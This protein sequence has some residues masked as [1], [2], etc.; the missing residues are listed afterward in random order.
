MNEKKKKK[1]TGRIIAALLFFGIG[2]ALINMAVELKGEAQGPLL[3]VSAADLSAHKIHSGDYIHIPANAMKVTS[4]VPLTVNYSDKPD[5]YAFI[6]ENIPNY[7]FYTDSK[8]DDLYDYFSENKNAGEPVNIELKGRGNT[9]SDISEEPTG[10][11]DFAQKNGFVESDFF[12]A[13]HIGIT[14]SG[15]LWPYRLCLFAAFIPVLIG[16]LL[17]ISLF[18]RKTA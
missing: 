5:G 3:E 6:L 2:A 11:Y 16:L 18:S 17:L 9:R 4:V 15:Q 13:V 1:P 8:S 7:V 10:I 12:L 14:Q